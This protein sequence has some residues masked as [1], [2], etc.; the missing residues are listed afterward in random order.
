M[1]KGN[2][3][4]EKVLKW[5]VLVLYL[6]GVSWGVATNLQRVKALKFQ[7][8]DYGMYMQFTAQLADPRLSQ[9]LSANPL[10]YNIFGLEEVEAKNSLNQAIHFEPVKYIYIPLYAVFKGPPGIFLFLS[11]LY[12]T[13]LLYFYRVHPRE[14]NQDR[15]LVL[16]F[17]LLYVFTAASINS[18]GF[19]VRP[20]ILLMPA[21]MMT[22]LAVHYRRPLWEQAL[23]LGLMFLVREEALLLAPVIVAY[24]FAR[25]QSPGQRRIHTISLFTMW[26]VYAAVLYIYYRWTGLTNYDEFSYLDFFSKVTWYI[27]LVFALVG[28]YVV[29]VIYVWLKERTI[30][31]DWPVAYGLFGFG[32][33]F[34]SARFVQAFLG[35]RL[36]NPDKSVS[37]LLLISLRNPD[38]VLLLM[39]LLL[40]VVMLWQYLVKR[41][42]RQMIL[43]V[44]ALTAVISCADGFRVLANHVQ[45]WQKRIP[46]AEIIFE[47]RGVTYVYEDGLL[48]DYDTFQAFY[49][50]GTVYV[51]QR[52]PWYMFGG[53]RN[54]YFPDNIDRL[55]KIIEEEID[56]IAIS[57]ANQQQIET[58]LDGIPIQSSIWLENDTYQIY[59][60]NR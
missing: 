6:L 23:G 37:E 1:G 8:I 46:P 30:F 24:G 17:S 25:G 10:G 38:S 47:L 31:T 52:L 59:R 54:R 40:M 28:I 18:L 5:L 53:E 12:Y 45:T 9:G 33:L 34:A 51:Y 14:D 4:F 60:L 3:G 21:F 15:W 56:Y 13:P 49:D 20:R 32:A 58:I 57:A 39:M 55:E 41:Q 42:Q 22:A 48:V 50:Y 44:M 36:S 19:D 43:T 27:L 7:S 2:T 29:Y 26:L 16:L 35:R 11:L